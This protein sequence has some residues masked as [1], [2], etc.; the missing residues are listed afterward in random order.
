M[1][2]YRTMLTIPWTVH[3]S[4]YNVL[5]EMVT[6]RTLIL[7]IRKRQLKYLKH[8]TRKGSKDESSL[9]QMQ[10]QILLSS[11][12]RNL[13]LIDHVFK[14]ISVKNWS[15]QVYANELIKIKLM[16]VRGKFWL[17]YILQ[18]HNVLSGIVIK[19]S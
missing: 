17:L 5:G 15:Y 8:I 14:G 16:Q 19:K 6:K 11:C 13:T 2:F 3:V 18:E 7:D 12:W 1:W 9:D 4:N 10:I